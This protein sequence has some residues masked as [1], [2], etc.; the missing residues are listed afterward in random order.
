M[1]K[2]HNINSTVSSIMQHS[3]LRTNEF[4][5][6]TRINKKEFI[7]MR[8]GNIPYSIDVL[9]QIATTFRISLDTIALGKGCLNFT[10]LLGH[11]CIMRDT[12]RKFERMGFELS[13]DN[14]NWLSFKTDIPKSTLIR[15]FFYDYP[16]KLPYRKRAK[17]YIAVQKIC[18]AINSR[19][20]LI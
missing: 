16:K 5:K 3:G 2:M 11:S 1:I 9:R 15:L 20:L 14:I 12:K 19:T 17:N 18:E 7:A 10:K 13:N 4:C 8:T 6:V